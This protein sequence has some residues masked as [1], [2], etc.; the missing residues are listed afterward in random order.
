FPPNGV[1]PN[2]LNDPDTGS[3]LL[4]NFPVLTSVMALGGSTTIQGTLN[5][6]PNTTYQIDFYTSPALDPSGNG[7]GGQFFNSTAVSTDSNGNATINVTFPALVGTGRVVTATA[8]DPAGNTS[9]FSAGNGAGAS[10]TVQFSV[11]SFK[12]IEDVGIVTIT[13]LRSGGTT[14]TLN[15]DYA[16]ANGT[17]TA[18]QDYTATSGTL[19]FNGGESSKTFQIPILD[20]AV[21]E[22]DETFTVSLRNA[23]SVDSLGIPNV[24][25]ITVQDHS[26]VPTFFPES[27]SVVE[28]GPGTTTQMPF[29]VN[30]SAA[31]GRTVSV[32]FVTSNFGAFGGTSCNTRGVDYENAS[33]TITFQPGTSSLPI[34]VKVCGDTNAEANEFLGIT[35]SN[36][37]NGAL[38]NTQAFGQITDDDVLLLALEEAG[39][40]ANQAAALDSLLLLR[41]PFRVVGIP[42]FWPTGPDKNARVTLFAKNL[43]LNPGESPSEVIVRIIGAGN[44]FFDVP[45]EA[46]QPIH[47]FEFTEVVIRL[48]NT[49][50]VGTRT[51]TI[52]AHGRVSNAGVIRIQ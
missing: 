21:T 25:T 50:P 37:V 23:P 32:N 46:V 44:Q 6:V 34:P 15:V 14:G 49:V 13:V 26:T 48:P 30:L 16:T 41:D 31:T 38:L 39:P 27:A 12:V 8:T 40:N 24:L 20:D 5:S 4:Q 22:F 42:D 10:G 19:T 45:A 2:D 9:E 17:A 1:T 3:N 35:L 51:V 52:R 47:N 18:G 11:D 36:P 28:G 43:E 29:V 7:E 33:G